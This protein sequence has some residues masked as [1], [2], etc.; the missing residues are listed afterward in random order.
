LF[1]LLQKTYPNIDLSFL[2]QDH[3]ILIEKEQEVFQAF[4]TSNQLIDKL[5]EFD[6]LLMQHLSE[7]EDVVEPM[8]LNNIFDLDW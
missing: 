3:D 2:T 4:D 1:P 7:E 8:C 6:R 5:V